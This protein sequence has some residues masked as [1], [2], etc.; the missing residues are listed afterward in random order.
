MLSRFHLIPER[1]GRTDRQT[2]LIYQYRASVVANMK[3]ALF[4]TRCIGIINKL[5]LTLIS[6]VVP[7]A[8]HTLATKLNSTRSTS[9]KVDKVD[10]V[11][12][13]PYTL[14]TTSK[15]RSTFGRRSRPSWRQC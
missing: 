13:F 9:L 7:K 15:G 5:T 11:A 2:D 6:S 8:R 4:E 3:L 12:L 14:A 1:H 10:R